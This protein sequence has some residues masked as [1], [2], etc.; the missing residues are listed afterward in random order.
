MK[1]RV[2]LLALWAQEQARNGHSAPRYYK[3]K[4]ADG[5]G[6]MHLRVLILAL[7]LLAPLSGARIKL[8]LA[9]GGDLLVSEYAVEGDRVRYYSVERSAWEVIPLQLVNLERTQR[10]QERT[11]AVRQVR[12]KQE[13]ALRAAERRARTELHRVPLEDGVYYLKG[14]EIVP[15]QQAELIENNSK[16]AT[17]LRVLSPLP[18]ADK[19]TL[20]VEGPTSAFVAEDNRPMFYVRLE[21]ISRLEILRLKAKSKRRE[22]QVIQTI[23]ES[24]E[25]IET[26]EAVEIFRQQLA[27]HVYKVWSVEP[28]QTGDYAVIEYTSGE[29]NLRVWDF[30]VGTAPG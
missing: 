9:G 20:E 24:K 7:A 12:R 22:V 21:K 26:H 10:E 14:N 25:V 2:C 3:G 19:M 23:P 18:T 1:C 11:E 16:T 5:Y 28:L 8:Y 29:A 17:L 6:S 27:P 30:S 4:V 13:Q 15:V